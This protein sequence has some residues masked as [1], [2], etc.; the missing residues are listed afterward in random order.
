[1]GNRTHVVLPEDLLNE[2]DEVAG[3]RRRS[4]FIEQAVRERLLWIKQG[5]ALEKAIG[6]LDLS[7]YPEWD[8]PE[9]V[10]AWVREQRQADDERLV[11]LLRANEEK[12][13]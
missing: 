6:S 5:I 12:A 3:K 9:K 7:E 8:T 10:S 1:M 4:E 2:I 11:E 13:S